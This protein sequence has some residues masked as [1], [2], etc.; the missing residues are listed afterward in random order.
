[1][2]QTQRYITLDILDDTN[3]AFNF[4]SYDTNEKKKKTWKSKAL[5]HYR[6][7]VQCDDSLLKIC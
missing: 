3:Q 6:L 7:S 2:M 4:I 5:S 1:M